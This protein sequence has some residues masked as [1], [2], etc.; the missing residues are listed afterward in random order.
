VQ[1]ECVDFF[2]SENVNDGVY[3]RR[4][5]SLHCAPSLRMNA[6]LS[7]SRTTC[8]EMEDENY[9]CA[10]R[11]LLLPFLPFYASTPYQYF[12]S[13]FHKAFLCA[14]P[15]RYITWLYLLADE[16]GEMSYRWTQPVQLC[17]HQCRWFSQW[18]QVDIHRDFDYLKQIVRITFMNQ[19]IHACL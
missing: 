11:N 3:H 15:T 8:R 12:A 18:C 10:N 16:S 6:F 13:I 7:N 1:L 19:S 9:F 5:M 17:Y 2:P 4:I 14:H